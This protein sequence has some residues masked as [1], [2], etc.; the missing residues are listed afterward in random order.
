MKVSEIRD[1]M[2]G[3]IVARGCFIV[4]ISVSKDNDIE[5]TIESADSTVEL[6]DC[7]ELSR[8]FEEKFD[9]DKED[10]SLTV[11]SA[12]LDQPFRVSEQFT[13]AIGKKVEIAFKGGRKLV[14]ILSDA[15]GSS[16]TVDYTALEK[17]EGGK[18]K[19]KVDH[20]ETYSLEDTN[21]VK[22]FIDF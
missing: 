7:V 9:R 18:K 11:S 21:S 4:D 20:H 16:V 19:V 8:V 12:G 15:D 1:A 5:I 13:K 17:P 10:Y 22:Y 2:E 14:G 3:A 6:D